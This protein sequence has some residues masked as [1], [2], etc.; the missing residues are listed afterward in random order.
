[1]VRKSWV[2][3][4]LLALP[5]GCGDDGHGSGAVRTPAATATA[6]ASP[7]A[8]GPAGSRAP[9]LVKATMQRPG[10]LLDNITI[11]TDGYA[12][13]DRPSGGVGRVQRDVVIEPAVLRRLRSGL[14]RVHG[15]GGRPSGAPDANPANYILR[16]HGRTLVATQGAES[17]ELRGPVHILRAMLLDGEGFQKVTRERLGGAAG[18]THLAGIGKEKQA[19]VLVFFQRQ[20]AGGATLDTFT[21]RRDGS[22]R[23]E[24]RYGGAGGRFKDLELRR[25]ALPRL[26][27]ALAR[28]PRSGSTLTRGSPPP[29]GAQYLLRYRG[30][31]F[32]AREGGV[33]RAARPAVRI[34]DGFIDGIG[35]RRVTR[36]SSTNNP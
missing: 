2:A 33:V 34:L 9:V 26:R 8:A 4:A 29:G 15:D 1:M 22:G 14:A 28:L 18:A 30:R 11:H 35:V 36:E 27:A 3:A 7:Q 5:A 12:L 16:Y 32:T 17:R 25:G 13:F 23:L 19:P 21:V 6:T 31:T 20:G 24:K 10:A